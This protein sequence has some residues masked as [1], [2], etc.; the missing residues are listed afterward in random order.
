M[1]YSRYRAAN[2]CVLTD[3]P[4]QLNIDVNQLTPDSEQS[5]AFA[6]AMSQVPQ[7]LRSAEVTRADYNADDQRLSF[8]V[9]RAS[10]WDSPQLFVHSEDKQL[11]EVVFKLVQQTVSV[12]GSV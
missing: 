6:Q 1:L 7:P 2:I 12:D 9:S 8:V 11:D 5:F 4:L 10:G 3:F